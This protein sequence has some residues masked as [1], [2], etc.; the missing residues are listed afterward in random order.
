MTIDHFSDIEATPVTHR[1]SSICGTYPPVR[2]DDERLRGFYNHDV[3]NPDDIAAFTADY[4]KQLE[5]L[6]ND[7]D[8]T[9]LSIRLI[10]SRSMVRHLRDLEA[11]IPFCYE[12]ADYALAYVGH[13]KPGRSSSIN[14]AQHL[15]AIADATSHAPAERHTADTGVRIGTLDYAS[16]D[17]ARQDIARRLAVPYQ[18]F[19]FSPEDVE[20]ALSRPPYN[21]MV[22]ALD[23]AGEIASVAVAEYYRPEFSALRNLR[24]FEITWAYT[25]P[26]YRRQGLYTTLSRMLIQRIESVYQGVH[27]LI[28]GEA[29]LA[30]SGVLR[31][32]GA[33]GRRFNTYDADW[34][35]VHDPFFGVLPQNTR[36]SEDFQDFVVTYHPSGS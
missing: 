14:Y 29:N 21:N 4:Q 5:A 32:A 19:G 31:A 6:H 22:Y 30:S 23:P 3:T 26:A 33:N 2:S 13:N 10:V 36:I 35:G 34:F 25:A 17:P 1:L 20:H 27:P 15:T 7:D 9:R 24:L 11:A 8:L 12:G 28:F 16:T 18:L